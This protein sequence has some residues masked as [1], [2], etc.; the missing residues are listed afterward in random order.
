MK[1]AVKSFKKAFLCK[2]LFLFDLVQDNIKVRLI[3][4]LSM[5]FF[6]Y[7]LISNFFQSKILAESVPSSIRLILS[8]TEVVNIGEPLYRYPIIQVRDQYDSPLENIKVKFQFLKEI[9]L[10]KINL[11][12]CDSETLQMVYFTLMYIKALGPCSFKI[13]QQ[14]INTDQSGFGSFSNLSISKASEGAYMYTI[15][16]NEKVKLPIQKLYLTSIVKS[17]KI[18][19]QKPKNAKIGIPFDPQP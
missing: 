2:T 8:P 12:N 16:A 19:K 11:I 18:L 5:L 7:F 6:I 9:V 4:P 14:Y 10:T 13:S 3:I 1:A 17:I 15:L